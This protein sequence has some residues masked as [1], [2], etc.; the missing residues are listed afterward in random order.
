MNYRQW[1]PDNCVQDGYKECW[2][3]GHPWLAIHQ[4]GHY[5]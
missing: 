3:Q 2:N 1:D 5:A 4:E